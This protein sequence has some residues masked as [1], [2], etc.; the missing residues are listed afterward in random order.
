[1]PTYTEILTV[2]QKNTRGAISGAIQQQIVPL[3]IT[4]KS[5]N[6]T[7]TPYPNSYPSWI[8]IDVLTEF[9]IVTPFRVIGV[10]VCVE[11][12]GKQGSW[13]ALAGN[14]NDADVALRCVVVSPPPNP[15]SESGFIPVD[16]DG[17]FHYTVSLQSGQ[18]LSVTMVITG[19]VINLVL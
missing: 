15:T 2:G 4:A 10:F 14:P 17:D 6:W 8:A 11:V 7:A 12:D 5:I 3:P 9:G 1:M 16:S 18:P 19:Y 13:I